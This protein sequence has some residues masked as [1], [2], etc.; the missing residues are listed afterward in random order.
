M[1]SFIRF[2][3]FLRFL[4]CLLFE[5]RFR[6]SDESRFNCERPPF[7]NRLAIL[8]SLAVDHLSGLVLILRVIL[9]AVRSAFELPSLLVSRRLLIRALFTIAV[10]PWGRTRAMPPVLDSLRYRNPDNRA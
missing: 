2:F 10:R 3:A 7:L 8:V 9:A 5:D 6:T 1:N 4:R